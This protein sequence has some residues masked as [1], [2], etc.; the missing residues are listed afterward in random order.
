[1]L[2]R[3]GLVCM[4]KASARGQAETTHCM[5]DADGDT[6][7]GVSGDSQGDSAFLGDGVCTQEDHSH[8]Y[9]T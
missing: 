4:A 1:M 3:L 7:I 2:C 9:S 6:R 8:R 5:P